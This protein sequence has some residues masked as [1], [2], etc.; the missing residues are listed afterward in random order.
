MAIFTGRHHT[1]ANGSRLVM[2]DEFEP[3]QAERAAFGDLIDDRTPEVTQEPISTP[4][5]TQETTE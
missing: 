1:R 2:G 4:E 3:T 5:T